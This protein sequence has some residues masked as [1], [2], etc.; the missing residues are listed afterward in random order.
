MISQT[1]EEELKSQV[2]PSDTSFWHDIR[3]KK[4]KDELRPSSSSSCISPSA[5]SGFRVSWASS[6][7]PLEFLNYTLTYIAT[8]SGE[9]IYKVT[10]VLLVRTRQDRVGDEEEAEEEEK[11]EG[12]GSPRLFDPSDVWLILFFL[13]LSPLSHSLFFSLSSLFFLS[14]RSLRHPASLYH[15]TS[16]SL[17]LSA[18]PS[19][20]GWHLEEET[21]ARTIREGEEE[22]RRIYYGA[23]AGLILRLATSIFPMCDTCARTQ[24]V[25]LGLHVCF[26]AT[27]LGYILT[28]ESMDIIVDRC[29]TAV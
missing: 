26:R 20:F 10:R 5:F 4:K 29:T 3:I 23:V 11:E 8:S 25:T 18:S 6:V 16:L 9:H 22:A 19:L 24:A 2:H 1:T 17:S 15:P 28:Y 14:F 12:K 27:V 21:H 7:S 13:S